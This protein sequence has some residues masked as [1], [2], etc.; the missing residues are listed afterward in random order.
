MKKSYHSIAVPTKLD[1]TALRAS[2]G[3]TVGAASVIAVMNLPSRLPRT[4][5]ALEKQ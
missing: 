3:D 4:L 1:R 2:L 5:I